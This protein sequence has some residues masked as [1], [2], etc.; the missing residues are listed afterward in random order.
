MLKIK[1][2][3]E[4]LAVALPEKCG[5]EINDKIIMT[6]ILS[7]VGFAYF[8][9]Y[10]LFYVL[11]LKILLAIV[12][13]SASIFFLL[14][15]IYLR[16][17]RKWDNA[18][19]F[20]VLLTGIVAQYLL[21]VDLQNAVFWAV[22]FPVVAIF[23]YGIRKGGILSG[24]YLLVLVGVFFIRE[25]VMGH[26]G[27]DF[28]LLVLIYLLL[29]LSTCL[30]KFVQKG[31]MLKMI[32]EINTTEKEIKI[33]D[34]FISSLSHQIR[35]SLNNIL[36]ATNFLSETSID[37]K[38]K[39]LID[40][41]QASAINLNNVVNSI[42]KVSNSD[43][44]EA[45]KIDISFD[46]YSTINSIVKLFSDSGNEQVSVKL[47]FINNL[48]N[49]LMGDPVKIKQVF[50]S[51]IEGIIKASAGDKTE[52]NIDM[53][54][55]KETNEKA[56]LSFVITSN[57]KQ[58]VDK[59][60]LSPDDKI[61]HKNLL[62]I[63]IAK[64]LVERKGSK[65]SISRSA[66]HVVFSFRL[67]AKKDT[68]S[69]SSPVI[70]KVIMSSL[71][72]GDRRSIDLKESNV[73]LV[74]DNLI[75][76]KI[77]MLSLQKA[78]KNIDIANNGKEALDKF[79]TSKYDII[80]MDIQMPVMDGIVTTKKIREIETS[81]SSHT[82]I[83]A[84]TANALSGD[85]EICLAAGMNDYISKPFQVETLLEKMQNMLTKES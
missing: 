16:I 51:I 48:T 71:N 84:L 40:T 26:S 80:L 43:I 75:N 79:G 72:L 3:I 78:V 68:S 31:R 60:E 66:E 7:L 49:N 28:Y 56:V 70:S 21:F 19:F 13:F 59:D 23:I 55:L 45:K 32:K 38:Q 1:S 85:K 82:P 6:N 52:I 63:T 5:I 65:I 77:V 58:F 24:I 54:V 35:T 47:N 14:D 20:P 9:L 53:Q 69:V 34:E 10:G 27:V 41:L 15:N 12:A 50:L 44:G 33:K 46:L 36:V 8:L 29:F 83:I 37:E 17:Y 74:E 81:T 42:S 62:E 4:K 64:K 22:I 67:L 18:A 39:D 57:L 73:L 25:Q 61:I 11:S 76:Q 2:I 30:F